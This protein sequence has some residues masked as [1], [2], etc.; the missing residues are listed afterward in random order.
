MKKLILLLITFA[1]TQAAASGKISL[2]SN[3]YENGKVRPLIGLSVYERILGTVA[4]N[5]FAGYGVH[6]LEIRDD[7]QWAIAKGQLDVRMQKWVVSP[8]IQYKWLPDTDVKQALGFV[9]A[10]YDLW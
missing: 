1:S 5:G 2:Q 9:K 6:E 4:F 3:M 10:S 8:G 7:V